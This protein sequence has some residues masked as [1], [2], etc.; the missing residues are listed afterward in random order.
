[1]PRTPGSW[2]V[3]QLPN[4]KWRARYIK[5][6]GKERAGH[7]DTRKAGERWC[8]E[9]T[10]ATVT[11]QYVDPKAGRVTF[12]EYAEGWRAN[13]VHRPATRDRVERTLRLHVYAAFGDRPIASIRTTQV[14]AFVSTAS[15]T[16]APKSLKVAYSVV[17]AVFRAAVRDR[18]VPSSPCDGVRLPEPRRRRV[19]V[20]PV[21]VLDVHAAALPPRLAAVVP[22]V[23]GSGLRFGEVAGLE[24]GQLDFLRGREVEVVQ[25]VV[26]LGDG[27]PFLGPVKTP[28][29]ER[30]VPLA[31]VTLDALAAHLAA[32][33]PVE[34]EVDVEDRTDPRRVQRRTVQLV[35]ALDGDQPLTRSRWSTI[36]T[37]AARAAG[38]PPRT[39]L[40]VLRH[41][42]ASL[43]IRH[44]ESVKT[45]QNRLGHSSAAVTLDTYSHMWPDADDTTRA[46]VELALGDQDRAD[47]ERTADRL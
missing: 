47:S 15:A 41:L 4:G 43:L 13:C 1:M 30:R 7:F 33:P 26:T 36:W 5:P 2:N 24:V 40:H 35:F 12:R 3:S 31:Q 45:V 19:E 39:G 46:A 8:R 6:D 18:V 42:Y 38:L 17:V 44:G 37:P 10:A 32:F 20:P 28:E 34:V 25:Q 23:A 29:S 16:L 21:D 11:G 22:F 9:Q 14:R 27:V